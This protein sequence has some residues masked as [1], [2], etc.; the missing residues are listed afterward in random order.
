MRDVSSP[1]F[2]YDHF[3]RLSRG[4]RNVGDDRGDMPGGTGWVVTGEAMPALAGALT[5]CETPGQEL[6]VE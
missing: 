1:C 3:E 6:V 4:P 2:A 5:G